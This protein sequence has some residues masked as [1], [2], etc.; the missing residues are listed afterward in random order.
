M[1]VMAAQRRLACCSNPPERLKGPKPAP[2]CVC[3]SQLGS[4]H[5]APGQSP[6][7][8]EPGSVRREGAPASVPC[9]FRRSAQSPS[10]W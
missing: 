3:M 4:P 2:A 1:I 7:G 5:V 8:E 6:A 9:L 10:R